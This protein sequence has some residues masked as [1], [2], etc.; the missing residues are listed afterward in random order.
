M[1]TSQLPD[2]LTLKDISPFGIS[3]VKLSIALLTLC[4]VAFSLRVLVR[5]K[6]LNIFGLDDWLMILALVCVSGFNSENK[7]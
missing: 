4:W 1:S 2:Y 6:Y 3:T 7:D 5:C